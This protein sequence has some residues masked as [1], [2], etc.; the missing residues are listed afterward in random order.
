M[1]ACLQNQMPAE[2]FASLP[3]GAACTAMRAFS[4]ML[5]AL[6]PLLLHLATSE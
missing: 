5:K 1:P 2:S 6:T 4:Q 3:E